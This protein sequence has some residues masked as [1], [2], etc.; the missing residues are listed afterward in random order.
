MATSETADFL[1]LGAGIVGLTTAWELRKRY[2]TA[3]ILVLEKELRPGLHASGRNSGVLHSGIYYA[4][5]TLKAKVC[6]TG[7]VRMRAFAAEYGIACQKWGKVIVPSS[8]EEWVSLER[9]LQNARDNGIRAERLDEKGVRSIEPHARPYKG[10]IYSP[11]TA[12]IDSLAVLHK[13]CDL[14][15]DKNVSVLFGQEAVEVDPRHCSVTTRDSRFP[16]GVLFNCAG[17]Q[18]DIIARQFGFC[19]DY[20]LIPFKGIYY[21]LHSSKNDWVKSSIYPV[22]DPHLPFLG[23]HLT[24]VVNGDVYVGPTAIPALGRENYGLWENIH[25]RESFQVLWQ[26]ATLYAKNQ[27]NFRQLAH[28]ELRKYIKSSFLKS[29][30]KLVEGLESEDLVPCDKVGIRPQLVN[31]K[32]KRLE[33]DYILEGDAR[34]LHVL[35][36]ISPAF[37]SSFA[38]AEMVVNRAHCY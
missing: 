34:S 11:D 9:L 17:A 23:V 13:L 24:R 1:V 28:V 12:V 21:K 4:A 5:D 36:A 32:K 33:M 27:Q 38:F 37:T 18:A 15:K 10:G 31:V 8:E 2:A 30:C 7:S 3:R 26:V 19:Q 35:N 22:P 6:A 14:L 16:Y 25:W 20:R 29:A